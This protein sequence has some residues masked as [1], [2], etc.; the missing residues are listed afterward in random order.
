MLRATGK[1]IENVKQ[2]KRGKGKGRPRTG[3]KGPE[4]E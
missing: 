4:G 1:R 2:R 3:H